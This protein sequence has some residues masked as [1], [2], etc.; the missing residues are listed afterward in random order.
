MEFKVLPIDRNLNILYSY[1]L[2]MLDTLNIHANSHQEHKA[3]YKYK[4]NC[5]Y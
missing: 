3:I 5:Y 2:W 4:T 1:M